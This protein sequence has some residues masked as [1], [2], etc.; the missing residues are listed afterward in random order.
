MSSLYINIG[1]KR[2]TCGIVNN[3]LLLI[4]V[5]ISIIIHIVNVVVIYMNMVIIIITHISITII[6]ITISIM[7][8]IPYSILID[9][10]LI[11]FI[12]FSNRS[13]IVNINR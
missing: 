5:N 13:F 10:I 11:M 1:V 2:N 3:M 6:I 9:N 12:N 4:N 7:N 8:L